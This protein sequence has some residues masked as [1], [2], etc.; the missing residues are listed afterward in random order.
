[1]SRRIPKQKAQP[2]KG[3]RNR[4]PNPLRQHRLLPLQPRHLH[5]LQELLLLR[6]QRELQFRPPVCRPQV[7]VSRVHPEH[8]SVLLASWDR[9]LYLQCEA[10]I[11]SYNPPTM[12][13]TMKIITLT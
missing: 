12:T 4:L 1:M 5:L 9:G 2:L 8:L 11:A 7:P 3:L 10:T 13:G 6:Q